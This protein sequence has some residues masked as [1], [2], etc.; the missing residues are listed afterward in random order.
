[1]KKFK[2]WIIENQLTSFFIL[3]YSFTWLLILPV[4]ITGNQQAYGIFGLFGLFGPAIMNIV[5]S[6]KIEPASLVKDK[7]KWRVTFLTVW[8][9]GTIAFS[10]N[11]LATSELESPFA[12]IIYAVIALLP[13]IL[14]ASAFSKYP[15]V[16]RSL[17]SLVKPRGHLGYYLF[18]V[19]M[20]PC[21]ILISVPLTKIIGFGMISEPD[22]PNGFGLI[23]LILGS[24]FYGFLFAGGLNE[25]VGWTGF[26]LP[27]LQKR[28]N[29]LFSSIILWFFWI[30]WHIPLQ[31]SGFWNPEKEFLIRALIGTFFARFILTWLFNKTRG[32]ILPAMILH[33]T[34]NVCFVVL[35]NTD[36]TTILE[37]VLAIAII[38]KSRMW[39][40]I[41]VA[42]YS[43]NSPT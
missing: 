38:V 11:V 8:I 31:L 12:V 19:L 26:A 10:L 28:F 33:V 20:V 3:T 24:F 29:P 21:L 34:A 2:A 40:K 39:E 16:R 42:T 15:G 43:N 18:A 17:A 36:I 4:I 30:L 41:D 14:Y 25:E 6:R 35:P 37:A 9:I 13:A 32:G 1:M 7:L 23:T 27:R 5:I 22:L